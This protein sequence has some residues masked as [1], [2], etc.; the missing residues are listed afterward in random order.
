[1]MFFQR[2]S[3]LK[4]ASIKDFPYQVS[5][6]GVTESGTIISKNWIVTSDTATYPT[7]TNIALG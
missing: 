5:F 6:I 4:E 7:V 2:C 3:L 1:M